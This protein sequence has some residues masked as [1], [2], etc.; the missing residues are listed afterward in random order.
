MNYLAIEFNSQ[1]QLSSVKL[2][3]LLA[4]KLHAAL[5]SNFRTK[6]NTKLHKTR[7]QNK[8]WTLSH[9]IF[10]WF[11]YSSWKTEPTPILIKTGKELHIFNC[12]MKKI[13]APYK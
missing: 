8:I 7:A 4:N 5:N 10:M 2:R 3:Q 11:S 9:K 12:P 1:T 6:S 13:K